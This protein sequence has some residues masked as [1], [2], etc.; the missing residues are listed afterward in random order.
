[1]VYEH[2]HWHQEETELIHMYIPSHQAIV[3][4]QLYTTVKTQPDLYHCS[5]PELYQITKPDFW[6]SAGFL[7]PYQARLYCHNKLDLNHHVN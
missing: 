4:N 7:P 3:L 1:M 6:F 5:K 2:K